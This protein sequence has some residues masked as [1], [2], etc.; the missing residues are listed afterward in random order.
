M[1]RPSAAVS[2]MTTT[3]TRSPSAEWVG[4]TFAGHH[5][6]GEVVDQHQEAEYAHGLTDV[7]TVRT[8]TGSTYRVP[9]C[10]LQ[11]DD[12]ENA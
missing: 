8:P 3:Q 9:E 5:L 4:F 2:T 6:V 7:Y 1:R 11:S 12:I 10:D